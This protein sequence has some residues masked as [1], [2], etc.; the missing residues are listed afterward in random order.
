MLKSRFVDSVEIG[1][2]P[3]GLRARGAGRERAPSRPP[4][5]GA[6]FRASPPYERDRPGDAGG[7]FNT[8]QAA[9]CNITSPRSPRH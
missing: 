4:P 6:G 5:F 7:R 8:S 9:S 3:R 1:A 2:L